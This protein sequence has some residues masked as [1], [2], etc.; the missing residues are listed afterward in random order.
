MISLAHFTPAT[1]ETVLAYVAIIILTLMMPPFQWFKDYFVAQPL[2]NTEM[3]WSI[4]A[5]LW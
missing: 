4:K 1:P 5:V 2:L 3:F